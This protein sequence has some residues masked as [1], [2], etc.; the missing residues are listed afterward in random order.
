MTTKLRGLFSLR[1]LILLAA[2]FVVFVLC[3]V[4]FLNLFL[5]IAFFNGDFSLKVFF[6]L[7]KLKPVQ[8]AVGN[9][10]KVCL[11]ISVCSLLIAVPLAW[12]LSRWDFPFAKKF[13]SWLSLPYAI[14]PYIGAIAWIYLANPTTGLLNRAF[15]EPIFN[16]YSMTGLVFV[17]TS[18]LYTFVFLGTLS[19]LDRMDSSFEEAARLSGASPLR[20][21]RDITLPMIRP[22]LVSS[23][24]LVFLASVAS[25]GVPALIGGPARLYLLTTQIYTY[26]RM[27]SMSGLIRAAALAVWLMIAALVLMATAHF[28]S[29]RKTLQ[30]VSGKTSR[31]SEFELGRLRWPLFLL[32]CVFGVVVFVLPVGGVLLSSLSVTQG[33]LGWSNLTLANW[34]RVLFEVGETPRAISNSLIAAAGAATLASL[35][36]LFVAYVQVKTRL[37]GRSSFDFFAS[38]PYATP[39]TVVALAMIMTF[40]VSFMGVLPSLYNTLALILVAYFVKYLSFSVKTVTDG[41]RQIDDVLAEAAR[42]SGATWAQTMRTIWV[43]LLMPA[44]VASWFLVFMPALSEMTMSLLLTGPSLETIGTLTF[45]LQEYADASGG[46]AS[47]LALI[48]ISAVILINFLV[49]RLSRGKYGL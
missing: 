16:I 27:G 39:G 11:S 40:S 42:M 14:P 34:H 18:F 30:T 38:L 13:R 49:K 44:L 22:T 10:I 24:L 9:T 5:K 46:G 3:V 15:S 8:K 33:E 19:S 45:Q 4:P 21:F 35:V 41:Y 6:D 28:F 12:L 47:V 37:P 31:P 1:V 48:V 2:L 36:A 23:G 7:A 26:Q 20:V 29:T 32:V 25:F 17:E 43:P